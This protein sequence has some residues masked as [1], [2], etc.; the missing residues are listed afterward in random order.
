MTAYCRLR[1]RSNQNDL[2]SALVGSFARSDLFDQFDN[3]APEL[4]VGDARTSARQRQALGGGGAAG[5]ALEQKRNR[6]LQYFGDLLDAACAD[7]VGALFVFLNLLEGE[8]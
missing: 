3:A 2:N 1:C 4:G 7:P 6:D 8:A 5:T